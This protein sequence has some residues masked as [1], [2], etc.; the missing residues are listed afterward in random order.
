MMLYYLAT[1]T[2]AINMRIYFGCRDTFVT[3]HR[4]YHSQIGTTLK[5]MCCKGVTEG[6]GTHTLFYSGEGGKF[7]YN[8]EDRY[9]GQRFSAA[10]AYKY[11]IFATGTD[12][13]VRPL[14]R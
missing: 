3:E 7:L 6:V 11:T 4:L 14:A 10:L 9:S 1:Q 13:Y 2:T 12:I 8:M 5:Q